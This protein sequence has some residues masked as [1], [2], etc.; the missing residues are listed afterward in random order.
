MEENV[1]KSALRVRPEVLVPGRQLAPSPRHGRRIRL[2]LAAEDGV[3][4]VVAA[5]GKANLV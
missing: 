3:E 5:V 1:T 4:E 2:L